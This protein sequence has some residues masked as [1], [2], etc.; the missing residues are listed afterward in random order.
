MAKSS[1]VIAHIDGA[2]RG[3]PG[4]AAYA[5]VVESSDGSKL[6]GFSGY[7]GRATN[8]FAEYQ[9]L[10]AALEYALSNHYLRVHVQTDSE[11][12]ARQIEGVYKVK[13]PGLKPLQQ[14]A[15]QMIARLESFSIQHV[16][17][18][19]NHEADQLANQALE[20]AERAWKRDRAEGQGGLVQ[21]VS[22]GSGSKVAKPLRASATFHKGL[23][24]PH[25]Q[26]SLFEG[27]VVNLEIYRKE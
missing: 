15:R 25:G 13:S 16:P 20:A 14:Q 27:E 7:L 4:P 21:D 3:N 24:E 10:L 5:V 11:L 2:S 12:L 8:N 19:Q 6:A 23:L 22:P 26:L 1:E 17:R 18:E 9:A